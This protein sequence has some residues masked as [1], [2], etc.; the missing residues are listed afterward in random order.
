[1]YCLILATRTNFN[2]GGLCYDLFVCESH[3]SALKKLES[4]HK[5]FCGGEVE[6]KNCNKGNQYNKPYS[7]CRILCKSCNDEKKEYEECDNCTYCNNCEECVFEE[8]E[9]GCTNL[10]CYKCFYNGTLKNFYTGEDKCC[11]QSDSYN[12][13]NNVCEFCNKKNWCHGE[14]LIKVKI[15]YLSNESEHWRVHC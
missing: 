4:Y 2:A 1:M 10:E 15:Y 7:S 12:F 13:K 11:K 9:N 8:C 14:Y 6:C 3:E 5:D